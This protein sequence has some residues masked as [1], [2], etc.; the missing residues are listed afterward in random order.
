MLRALRIKD[1]AI[2]DELNL[3]FTEG[4]AVFSGET[5]AGKSIIVDAL[6][7]ITGGRGS[8]DIVRDGCE[9]TIIE[10]IFD[11][12]N[13]D[14][15]KEK[16]RK[17]GIEDN[18]NE[19]LVRRSISRSGRNRLYINGSLS[20]LSVLNDICSELIDIHGQ[21][22]HQTL[23]R[24]ESH[25][26]YLDAFGKLTEL[27]G[28]VADRYRVLDD[29][30]GRLNKLK[31]EISRKKEKE[32]LIRFQLSEIKGASLKTGEDVELEGERVILSNS[33]NLSALSHDAYSILY[34]NDESVITL[35][36][37][38]EHL[39]SEIAGIDPGMS[40]AADMVTTSKVNLKDA[41]DIL[42]RFM[43]RIRH[44]PERLES[45][46]ERIYY[47]DKLKKKYA[48][49]IED[50][51]L[52]Q[53]IL[54][55]DLTSIGSLDHDLSVL[56]EEIEKSLKDVRMLA[57]ELSESRR[58]AAVRFE[59]EVMSELSKLSM[60]N[61]K[62]VVN[63]E[64]VPLSQ[65]GVDAVEFLI[66][67]MNEEPKQLTRVA[68]GG[69]LSRIL[70]A[71]K[72]RL[73]S[74]DSVPTLIFD[75]VDAGIGGRVAEEVGRRLKSLSQDNQLFC[76]THLPQIAALADSH[77]HVEKVV[78]GDRVVTR[79][80][81]LDRKE[82]IEEISRMLGGSDRTKT[83]FRYAEEM[84]DRVADSKEQETAKNKRCSQH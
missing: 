50:I 11:S 2:I 48:R 22:E 21:H 43:D 47:L 83:A 64:S 57:D 75:E 59:N 61:I 80:R 46:N 76:V 33:Q 39:L 58:R 42:R 68:S 73:N 41:S 74:I 38:A 26:G 9:E 10:G 5:G 7:L 56:K 53:E 79:V 51:L 6:D 30:Q 14:L 72:S 78:T 84:L 8:S 1:L 49:T 40:D 31:E 13:K 4:F 77:Y 52:L 23:S 60:N 55:N 25:C 19:L 3:E 17:Y 27:R 71:I 66:A 44:D 69:E 20:T 67:N 35:L 82:R 15:H 32:D 62:F 12:I 36:S 81:Q 37:K 63:F 18:G 16:L 28:R 24:K 65:D 45:V 70:L 29:L 34:E 54:E